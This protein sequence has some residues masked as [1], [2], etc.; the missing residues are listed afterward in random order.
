MIMST[1]VSSSDYGKVF[2]DNIHGHILLHPL[3]VK[4]IDTP[5]FQRMRNIKQLGTTYLVYPCASVNR[6]EHSIGVCYLAGQMIEALCR[7][8]GD[9]I[10][11]TT[12]EKLCV[13]LAG[14]CH[15]LGHGP[16]SHSWE[17]YLKASG[18]DWK[19]EESSTEMLKYIIQKYDLEKELKIYGLNMEYHV[20]LICEFIRGEGKLLVE[21]HFLYQVVSNKDN[22]ID[23]DKWDYFLRDG[24][25]LNL[26]ISFDYKRLMQFSRV[27]LDPH[28]NQPK[29]VIAFRNKEARNIYDMF[30]VRSDLHLRAYQHTAVQNTELMWI[31]VL[32][33]AEKYF[34]IQISSGAKFALN[35]THTNIEA[36]S[37]LT[38]HILCDIQYS[39]D[40]KL[41]EAKS[42]LNRL[43]TRHLYKFIG[44]YNLIFINKEIYNKSIDVENLKES[45]KNELQKQFGIEFGVTATWLNCG[46]PLINPLEKVLFFKKPLYNNTSVVFDDTQFQNVYPMNELEFFKRDINVFSK[47]LK[48]EDSQ[49]KEIDLACNSF[50]MNFRP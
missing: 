22:G 32:L 27:V 24:N 26:S 50:L 6:F 5:E 21:N 10:N 8:S 43:Q 30:R 14:L 46:Y 36:M 42:L 23:V 37:R 29:Q 9:D 4:F 15:D 17:R 19:H 1:I 33:K 44:S 49:L 12:E 3:C 18:V 47:S 34:T 25:S 35:E 31:D 2:N 11:V 38:D 7:N 16:L 48:L 28:S 45:L 41:E 39:N 40:P 13:E 20:E